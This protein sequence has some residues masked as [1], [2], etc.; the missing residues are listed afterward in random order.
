MQDL[1]SKYGNTALITGASSGMGKAFAHHVTKQGINPILVARNEQ[2]LKSLSQELSKS[3]GVYAQYHSTDL[4][5]MESIEALIQKIDNQNISLFIHS[6]GLENNG[7]FTKIPLEKEMNVIGVN[8][9]ATYKLSRYFAEKMKAQGKGGIL[10][11]S[12]MIG[13][14]P[15]PYFTNYTASKAYTHYLGTSLS[16]ELKTFGVDVTVMAPGLTDTPMKDSTGVDWSKMPMATMSPEKATKIA[17][18]KLGKT[19]SVIPGL[20]NKMMV[21]M[22]RLSPTKMFSTMNGWMIKRGVSPEKL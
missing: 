18:S 1:K 13:L 11:L 20:M 7:D 3:Y 8:V 2:R 22:A 16:T 14:M 21:L 9:I 6:A 19:T 15:S 17:L 10:L 12:S 4:S 5:N